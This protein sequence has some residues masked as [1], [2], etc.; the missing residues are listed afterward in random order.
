MV[1]ERAWLDTVASPRGTK[2]YGLALGLREEEAR[3]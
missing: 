1:N 2:S 3:G